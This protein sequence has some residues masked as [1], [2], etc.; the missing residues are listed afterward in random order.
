MILYFDNLITN[1]PLSPGLQPN[2][3][4]I[5]KSCKNYSTKDRYDITMY[6]LA[7]YAELTWDEV[8]IVYEFGKDMLKKKDEFEK[9]VK[10]LWPRAHI[11]YGRSDN[12][13]KFQKIQKKL[14]C[15][16]GDWIFYAGNN[17]HPFVAPDKKIL[18]SCLKKAKLLSKKNRYV[19]ICYSHFW[20]TYHMCNKGSSYRNYMPLRPKILEE[21]EDYFVCMFN[22]IW[23]HSMQIFNKRF[24]N[25]ML[26]SENLEGETFRKIEWITFHDKM[27]RKRFNQITVIPKQILCDHFDGYSFTESTLFPI[28]ANLFP[29]LFIPGGFFKNNIKIRYGY[30]DYKEGWTNVNP[31]IDKYRFQDKNGTDLRILI[32]EIPL[33]WKKRISRIDI[34]PNLN[35]KLLERKREE[36]RKEIRNPDSGLVNKK[37]LYYRLKYKIIVGNY[38]PYNLKAFLRKNNF[39]K[40]IRREFYKREIK[41]YPEIYSKLGKEISSKQ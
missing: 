9:F 15:L 30:N 1:I 14:N 19:S 39:I 13:K 16:K 36:I 37:S 35:K 2:L 22:E 26:F 17:D 34:N 23:G 3:D 4:D 8:V 38:M 32:D 24:M 40:K 11:F 5:R 12:Q 21:N 29:P 18:E 28:S 20:E 10:N 31:L 27:K 6:T 33:F 7:S 41:D 25:Y